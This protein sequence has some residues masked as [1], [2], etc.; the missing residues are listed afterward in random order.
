MTEIRRQRYEEY[1]RVRDRAR[2]TDWLREAA[3]PSWSH[4][5]HHRFT[6][7]IAEDRLDPEVFKRYLV[8]E[9]AFVV[10]AATVLGYAIAQAPSMDEKARLAEALHSLTTDQRS[11][12]LRTFTA[13]GISQDTSSDAPLPPAVLCFRDTALRA[14]AHGCYE[15]TIAGMLAAE[16]LYLTWSERAQRARPSQPHAAEW[17]ALHVT[18]GFE[19]QVTWMRGQLDRYGPLLPSHRQADA[20]Y[21]FGRILELEIAFH[22]AP[23]DSR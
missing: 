20:A 22:D 13:L 1:V 16:W 10:T 2:F 3:E 7:E 15:E 17:I 23:Y 12:F 6:Y 4:A 5:I 21:I 18:P 11:Y 19:R 14:A 8:N 9:Y